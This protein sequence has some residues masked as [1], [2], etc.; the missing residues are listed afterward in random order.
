M[1]CPTVYLDQS[2][3]PVQSDQGFL[4]SSTHYTASTDP[5]SWQERPQSDC[6]N[7]QVDQSLHC[8]HM[9][10]GTFSQTEDHTYEYHKL[11]QNDQTMCL[12]F[13]SVLQLTDPKTLFITVMS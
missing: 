13:V 5:L 8:L 3:H 12:L 11:V 7:A 1:T 4:N 6:M 2:L 9:Q 10:Y